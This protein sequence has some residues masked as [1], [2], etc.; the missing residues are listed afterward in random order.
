MI[1]WDAS[2][3]S[4]A[5]VVRVPGRFHLADLA[6]GPGGR[7]AVVAG[8]RVAWRDA[9]TWLA[10]DDPD[11]GVEGD[12][13]AASPLGPWTAAGD[14]DGLIALFDP[15]GPPGR[16]LRGHRSRVT[17]LAFS[18]DGRRLASAGQDRTVRVWDVD[19]AREVVTITG[20]SALAVALS[21]DGAAVV[22]GGDGPDVVVREVAT[23]R[24]RHRLAGAGAPIR[25]L[26]FSPDGARLVVVRSTGPGPQGEGGGDLT[27]WDA[28]TGALQ[29][30][31]GDHPAGVT[32]ATFSPDGHRLVSADRT[33]QARVWEAA[34]GRLLLIL[35]GPASPITRVAFSHDG[36]R[37][38]AAGGRVDPLARRGEE[39][40]ELTVWD[41]RPL[42]D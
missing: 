21:P 13:V 24:V 17:A 25:R 37:L 4:E 31:L 6:V 42:G 30:A 8:H 28:A 40:A 23:G 27:V 35:R 14:G 26:E 33:G 19:T 7:L 22:S 16:E 11:G 39:T 34:T 3:G 18:R 10:P 5:R 29:F 12:A 1:V 32:D 20:E 9:A 15:S 2:T 36:H 41:G 38:F